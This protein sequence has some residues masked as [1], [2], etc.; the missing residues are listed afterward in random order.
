MMIVSDEFGEMGKHSA[1]EYLRDYARRSIAILLKELEM[2][3][4]SC[5]GGPAPL[6]L[7]APSD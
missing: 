5:D 7:T 2:T 1:V 4:L 3:P 6:I